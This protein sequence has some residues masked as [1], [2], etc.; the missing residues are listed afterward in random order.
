MRIQLPI[1][2]ALVAVFGGNLSL[3]P[4]SVYEVEAGSRFWIDGSATTG[5]YTCAAARVSGAVELDRHRVGGAAT[6]PVD[7]FD[8]GV[9]RMNRDFREALRSEAYPSIRFELEEARVIDSPSTSGTWT[10][11]LAVGTL[12]IAGSSQR[13]ATRAEG[14][15]LADGRVRVRGSHPLAMTDFGIDP[16][17]GLLGLVRAHDRIVVRFDITASPR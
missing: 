1:L 8:C 7:S 5:R 11:V 14:L 16:P 15:E 3:G 13:V 10:R 9:A 2:A 6:I 12:T 4:T 17:S